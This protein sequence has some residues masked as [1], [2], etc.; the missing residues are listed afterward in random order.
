MSVSYGGDKITFEDGSTVGSGWAGFKNRIIN[1]GMVID[2]RGGT[3]SVSTGTAT[4]GVDRW[5]GQGTS[6]AGV[7]SIRQSSNYP[8]GFTQSLYVTVGTADASLAATDLYAIQQRIEGYNVADLGWGTADA[9]TVT[10]SFWVRSSLTGTFGGSITNSAFNRS[11]PFSYT[12]SSANTWEQKSI[13]ISGDTTGTWLTDN[14]VGMRVYW[15][16][17]I[18]SNYLGTAGSWAGAGYISATGSTNVMSSTSNDFYIT[19]VQLEKG[20]QATSFE[21]RPYGTELALCQRYFEQWDAGSAY[22]PIPTGHIISGPSWTFSAVPRVQKRTVPTVSLSNSSGS[23]MFSSYGTNASGAGFL[24]SGSLAVD[25]GSSGNMGIQI[26]SALSGT[27]AGSP[28]TCVHNILRAN[29]WIRFSA[30]L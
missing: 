26:D 28:G 25:T 3:I 20:S 4:Y 23:S 18:G 8:A 7:F 15:G 13:T 24:W 10:L 11:Y 1:G 21:Y 14:G 12:I 16:L 22:C 19:G 27:G 29:Q 9:K 6:S 2:Q 30:E 5:S 17:G